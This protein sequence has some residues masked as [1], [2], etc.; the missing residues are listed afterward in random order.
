MSFEYLER[1]SA[2]IAK[3]AVRDE[4]RDSLLRWESV[5]LTCVAHLRRMWKD[6]NRPTILRLEEEETILRRAWIEHH[7]AFL[8]DETKVST[9]IQQLFS[10]AHSHTPSSLHSSFSMQTNAR[11]QNAAAAKTRST[12][13]SSESS[14]RSAVRALTVVPSRESSMLP[15]RPWRSAR[16]GPGDLGS[17]AAIRGSK[18]SAAGIASS[19]IAHAVE[20]R[21]VQTD[22]QLPRPASAWSLTGSDSLLMILSFMIVCRSQS[23]WVRYDDVRV[24]R[25]L[26]TSIPLAGSTPPQQSA[27]SVWMDVPSLEWLAWPVL[28]RL[29]LWSLQHTRERR[30][31]RS[32]PTEREVEDL[33]TICAVLIAV[34]LPKALKNAASER[35][36]EKN[37]AESR[38][39]NTLLWVDDDAALREAR[40]WQ[41][42]DP[43]SET[44]DEKDAN[45]ML[46]SE[47]WQKR[48]VEAIPAITVARYGMPVQLLRGRVPG[49]VDPGAG[50]QQPASEAFVAVVMAASESKQNGAA[51][52]ASTLH[53]EDE[54]AKR[55]REQEI[56]VDAASVD[57][58]RM[59]SDVFSV[60]GFL[61]EVD[62]LLHGIML[63][64]YYRSVAGVVV[65]DEHAPIIHAG[66]TG[67][68]RE[69]MVERCRLESGDDRWNSTFRESVFEHFMPIGARTL[70]K[71]SV[72][73]F[74]RASNEAM[75][76]GSRY[77]LEQTQANARPMTVLQN[78]VG[79][80]VAAQIDLMLDRHTKLQMLEPGHPLHDLFVLN[81]FTYILFHETQG[82]LVRPPEMPQA[83]DFMNVYYLAAHNL[84]GQAQELLLKTRRWGMPRRPVLT[85]LCKRWMVHD[86]VEVPRD[87]QL[88]VQRNMER[89]YEGRDEDEDDKSFRHAA[90]TPVQ[91]IGVWY[92]CQDSVEKA[93]LTWL[94][95]VR[96]RYAGNLEDGSNLL[97]LCE[98]LCVQ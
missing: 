55:K 80:K 74:D 58:G 86:V 72:L 84:E 16:P 20:A 51:A 39:V 68:L 70:N 40:A 3:D 92:D 88:D 1:L 56:P 6:P 71:R 65:D 13:S 64:E 69:L 95:L 66:M 37:A 47:D 61:A 18:R 14:V 28:R 5:L 52:S 4:L 45:A 25:S 90:V 75:H 87:A 77:L 23:L 60:E 43:E 34:L 85:Y 15:R 54:D 19:A 93:I 27:A 8:T 57:E 21:V 82:M 17:A 22:V 46:V 12:G 78:E 30:L 79:V 26:L 73:F 91:A 96:T 97:H 31:S 94:F 89:K 41:P 81:F 32:W 53:D 44:T 29:R 76:L 9:P 36:A 10:K 2:C 83:V 24:H 50:V 48:A 59:W 63:H 11:T 7:A 98:R 67:A 33:E 49:V 62:G 38:I 42:V 35:S